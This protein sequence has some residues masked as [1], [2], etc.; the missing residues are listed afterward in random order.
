M[1][2]EKMFVALA[3]HAEAVL[4]ALVQR[5]DGDGV[6]AGDAVGVDPGFDFIQGGIV[7]EHEFAE[8]ALDGIG[9]HIHGNAGLLLDQIADGLRLVG[10][11]QRA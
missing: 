10:G 4:N 5:R 3:H 6:G 2:A 1:V 8:F 9:G 11:Q 7:A